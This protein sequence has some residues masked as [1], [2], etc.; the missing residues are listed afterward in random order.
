MS[1]TSVANLKA[2]WLNIA[3]ADTTHDTLLGV[4]LLQAESLAKDICHQPIAQE[5]VTYEFRGNGLQSFLLPYVKVPVALTTLKYR[6]LPSDT[7]ATD[8]GGTVYKLDHLHR[9]YHSTGFT[10]TMYEA[11]LSVGYTSATCPPSL[12]EVI[13]EMVKELFA[14]TGKE[15]SNER[16]GVSSVSKSEAGLTTT[17]AFKDLR[18]SFKAK[19]APYIARSF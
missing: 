1:V 8:T 15:D 17:V 10:Y 11:V 4:L 13:S 16:F 19:L 7:Y 5:S 14:L 2:Y 6:A 18:E 9:I 3:E 12:V